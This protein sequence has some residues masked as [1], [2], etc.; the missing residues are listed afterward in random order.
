MGLMPCVLLFPAFA[1]QGRDF[2]LAED[3]L[4]V[5]V[6]SVINCGMPRGLYS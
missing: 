4:K 6:I 5:I 1:A 2:K 3:R